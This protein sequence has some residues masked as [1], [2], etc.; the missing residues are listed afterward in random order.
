MTINTIPDLAAL[1][2]ELKAA[3]VDL[4]DHDD[5]FR[6]VL[7]GCG[8]CIKIL[9]LDGRLQ[10]MSEGGKSVMEVADFRSLK[11]CPW[12]DFWQGQGNADAKAAIAEAK[13][14]R[15]ARF[16][17][18]AKTAKG[19]DRYWE[20]QVSPI[21]GLDRKPRQLL[22]ISRDVTQQREME[23]R[24]QW[25]TGELT[26]RIKN[27]LSMVIAIANQ[28]LQGESLQDAR[29]AL[30]SRLMTL[31]HAH[32]VLTKTSWSAAPIETVVK[33]ALAPHRT[34]EGR[35]KIFG[36]HLTL[37]PKPALALALAVNELATNAA[38]YGAMSNREGSVA[39]RWET[40]TLDTIPSFVFI[41]QEF[42]GPHVAGP[43]HKGFGTRIIERL[44][45]NDF[46]GDVVLEYAP[47]GVI[48]RL[49][50]AL[51]NLDPFPE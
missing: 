29:D 19:N 5:V 18:A 20:V 50:T 37:E 7:A 23:E 6:S 10:F 33:E 34:G 38:K 17:G 42:D 43:S 27:I 47:E 28:T 8:D 46:R 49:T 2:A 30:T 26:H 1:N 21:F 3:G 11:G 22:S 14:G 25:L 40:K 16:T 15:T 12:P 45:A 31:S 48:C 36:P 39:V 44:L 13:A 41:W 51:K 4:A 35:F 32:D 24:Q 9:D